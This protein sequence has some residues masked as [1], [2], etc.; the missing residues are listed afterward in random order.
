MEKINIRQI[1]TFNTLVEKG[2]KATEVVKIRQVFMEFGRSFN[3]AVKKDGEYFKNEN[4]KSYMFNLEREAEFIEHLQKMFPNI[5]QEGIVKL[6]GILL[7][8]TG[9]ESESKFEIK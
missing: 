7:T 5:S 6:L 9:T 2:V 4:F 1:D 8:L 3:P